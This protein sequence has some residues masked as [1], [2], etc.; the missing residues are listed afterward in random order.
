MVTTHRLLHKH[1]VQK[2]CRL[3][4]Q[5]PKP[6][7]LFVLALWLCHRFWP[8]DWL[9]ALANLPTCRHPTTLCNKDGSSVL[10][11][12]FFLNAAMENRLFVFTAFPAYSCIFFF[13]C[14]TVAPVFLSGFLRGFLNP[15]PSPV[16]GPV[17]LENRR[18]LQVENVQPGGFCGWKA[19][20]FFFLKRCYIINI[21]LEF[22]PQLIH[23]K[24]L[25]PTA[26]DPV[27]PTQTHFLL[28]RNL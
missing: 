6:S 22:F 4:A 16:A 27:G 5:L 9:P 23:P 11:L 14:R 17:L 21:F 15:F 7:S 28:L 2:V 10:V 12:F 19:V 1:T 26:F 20:T 8:A 3:A 25:S 24:F 13:F 18:P